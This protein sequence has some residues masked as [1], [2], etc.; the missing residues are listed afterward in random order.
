MCMRHT[1]TH[2]H[3]YTLI[4]AHTQDTHAHAH[5][6]TK[7]TCRNSIN[8]MCVED[9]FSQIRSR[10]DISYMVS[11]ACGSLK[12]LRHCGGIAYCQKAQTMVILLIHP[13][14]FHS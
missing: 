2:T 13:S 1:H 4:Q 11:C 14:V 8:W 7:P 9:P 10:L 12:D 6:R 3:T 5:T